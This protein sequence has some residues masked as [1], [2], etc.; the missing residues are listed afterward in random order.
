M[1]PWQLTPAKTQL[2][3]MAQK[4]AS[5]VSQEITAYGESKAGVPSIEDNQ[6]LRAAKGRKIKP[7]NLFEFLRT[8]PLYGL[9][10]EI[11]RDKSG[12]REIE[13]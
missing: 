4:A 6:K 7:Q 1:A 11:E 9:D 8:S 13:L 12:S 10:L 5:N 3:N 2:S